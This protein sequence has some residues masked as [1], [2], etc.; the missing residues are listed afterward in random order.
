MH[1]CLGGVSVHMHMLNEESRKYFHRAFVLS[2]T[3]FAPFAIRK[4][5]HIRRIH[6]CT[7]IFGITKMVEYLKVANATIL[8]KCRQYLN[9]LNPPWVPTIES[10][11]GGFLIKMP[12]DI[13]DSDKAPAMDTMFSFTN[14]VTISRMKLMHSIERIF[15]FFSS[16][17]SPF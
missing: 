5:N 10:Q 2:N 12:D 6:K 1:I 4:S 17:F 3:A 11:G 16:I 13:Y 7:R 9:F 15:S 14:Q 8:S